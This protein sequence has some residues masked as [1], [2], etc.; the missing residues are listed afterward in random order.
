LIRKFANGDRILDVLPVGEATEVLPSRLSG[1]AAAAAALEAEF[2]EE[3]E[4]ESFGFPSFCS[5]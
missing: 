1:A 2:E 3:E 4:D 5:L